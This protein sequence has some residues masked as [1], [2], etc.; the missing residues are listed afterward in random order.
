M[1]RWFDFAVSTTPAARLS[2][3]RR[4]EASVSTA[5]TDFDW[6]QARDLSFDRIAIMFG[7]IAD[8]HQGVDEKPQ[9]D[10]GRQPAGRSMRRVDQSELLE[11]RHDVAHRSRRQGHRQDARQIARTDRFAGRQI[12]LDDQAKDFARALVE[13]RKELNWLDASG[14]S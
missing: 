13:L 2:P 4:P 8:L 1:S 11:I 12:A 6:P 5:S 14:R 10:L 3:E 7:E 9:T